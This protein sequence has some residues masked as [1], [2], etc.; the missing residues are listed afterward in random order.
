MP[1]VN[2]TMTPQSALPASKLSAARILVVDDIEANRD[3]LSRRLVR[4]G[5]SHIL[6][7]ADG[8]QALEIIRAQPLDLVLLDIMMPVMTGFDVLEAMAAEGRIEGLPVIVI[9][10]MN[11]MDAIVRA[12]ELGAEDF[13][14]KPFDPTLLRA[15]VRA[16]LEKKQ[17]RDGMRDELTR[18]QAELGEARHLQLALTPA[19]YAADGV[20]LDVVLEPAREIVG[21]LVDHIVLADGR[22]LLVLGDVSGKGAGAALIMAR[23]HALVRSLGARADVLALLA[24]PGQAA[25]ALNAELAA[26]N[27]SCMFITLLLAVFNPA[28]GRLDYV[29]CGHVPP[30]LRRASGALERLDT[31]R[32][33]PLGVDEDAIYRAATAWLYPGD[34]LL[35]VSDGITEAAAPDGA[36]FDD[37]G[38]AAWLAAP[39]QA[40]AT[41]VAQVRAFEAG[42]PAGD[43]L[44][45]LL[46]CR[47]A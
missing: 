2:Q 30:F 9:S 5:F 40:L 32:G 42:L 18:K 27:P 38:V 31:A 17:L 8:A 28:D 33:L 29:R 41:L 13:L 45:A 3:L 43:D 21:D 23:S 39:R 7:A 6:Q 15:R 11:E 34:S 25:A 1:A 46:L 35:V 20:I 14:L 4:L 19:P 37:A 47:A 12:I 22:H 16:T 26:N 24:E 44:S 10:A 36:L